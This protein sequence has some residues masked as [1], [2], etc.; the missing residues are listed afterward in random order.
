[1]RRFAAAAAGRPGIGQAST[2]EVVWQRGGKIG[3][4]AGKP[5]AP[6]ATA[7]CR[8][9]AAAPAAESSCCGAPLAAT[10]PPRPLQRALLAGARRQGRPSTPGMPLML[11]HPA[12][13]Q[14]SS[15]PIVCNKSSSP[16]D[17]RKRLDL[18]SKQKAIPSL[19]PPSDGVRHWQAP[20]HGSAAR[21]HFPHNHSAA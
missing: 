14:G 11:L 7:A 21:K 4:G 13:K 17:D 20:R 15:V 2:C 18:P 10:A 6:C 8:L 1:M 9:E 16:I 19:S 3:S 5:L 12:G